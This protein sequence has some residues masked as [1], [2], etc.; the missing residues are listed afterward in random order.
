MI[1]SMAKAC[2]SFVRY[3]D[4]TPVLA[5]LLL[6]A[7]PAS[8]CSAQSFS[9]A[10]A[11][12]A[13]EATICQNPKLSSLDDEL[14]LTFK[15]ALRDASPRVASKLTDDQTD[16]LIAR[17]QCGINASC[18]EALYTKRIQELKGIAT[19]KLAKISVG[20]HAGDATVLTLERPDTDNAAVYFRRELDDLVED[21]TRNVSPDGNGL[22][23]SQ[24]VSACVKEASRRENGQIYKRRARCSISTIYTEFGNFTMVHT[25]KESESEYEGKTYKPIRTDWKN[26]RTEQLAGN[27]NGCNTPQ[28]LSTFQVLCPASYK[29]YF[30]G[31]DPY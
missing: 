27:C 31:L 5:S 6:V 1:G 23:D 14:A 7:I 28:M 21:C 13:D 16:W 11:R 22:V 9:C 2:V 19:N 3:P 12:K 24:K 4:L 8:N 26:H 15:S 18:I 20:A 29:A 25:E 30:E 10:A 17:Y